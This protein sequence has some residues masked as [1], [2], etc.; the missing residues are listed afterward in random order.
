MPHFFTGFFLLL[1]FQFAY[2]Q[3]L[4]ISVAPGFNYSFSG[5][6]ASLALQAEKNNHQLYLGY[7]QPINSIPGG[8]MG[9]YGAIAGY[10]FFF[11][12]SDVKFRP[13]FNLD[14]QFSLD[15]S[16]YLKG[17]KRQYNFIHQINLGYGITY[18]V[19]PFLSVGNSIG[20]GFFLQNLY[21]RIEQKHTGFIGYD[22]LIR[23]FL[24]FHI[25]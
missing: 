24:N 10:R 8:F 12:D 25:L 6:S 18:R 1:S 4:S 21:S 13:F 20:G 2:S 14:Y 9:K 11:K 3:S 7:K 5:A 17:E 15:R 16:Y 22:G 23:L 19:L